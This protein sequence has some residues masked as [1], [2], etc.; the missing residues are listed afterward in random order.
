M[1]PPD[2][3]LHGGRSEKDHQD[4]QEEARISPGAV[5]GLEL[6]GST[7]RPLGLRDP[8]AGLIPGLLK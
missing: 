8:G 5:L 2:T 6:H 3:G 4:S 1:L 7:A